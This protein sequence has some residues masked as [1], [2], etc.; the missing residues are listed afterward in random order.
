[1]DRGRRRRRHGR[2]AAAAAGRAAHADVPRAARRGRRAPALDALAAGLPPS[3]FR[4][5]TLA[6]LRA[7]LPARGD[8]RRQLRAA[9]WP[10]CSRRSASLVLRQHASGG[11]AA[12]APPSGRARSEQAARAR[13][14]PRP[15]GP[16]R[17]ARRRGPP[18]VTVGDGATLV[19]LE[20]RWAATA[21]CSDG[22]ASSPGGAASASTWRRPRA[23][24]GATSP[25]RLSP[26]VLLRPVVESAL[27]PT[28]AYLGGPGELRYLALTPPV[29]AAPRRRRGSCPLPA[30]VG[31]AGRAP[32][33]P[34][35][36][37]VRRRRSTE[38]LAPARRA[39]GPAGA[40]A[41][42]AGGARARST[43]APR[44]ARGRATARSSARAVEIDPTLARPDAGR[45]AA[46][47]RRDPGHREEAGAAPQAAAGDRAG[48]DR[49]GADRGAARRQ[50]A[51]AGPDRGAVP[52]A[53][54]PGAARPELAGRDRGL[55]CRRP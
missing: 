33:G 18:G 12:A 22:A 28:V 34:R 37:E 8:R 39:R 4:D 42:A 51:G 50:A 32:G 54:R 17:W 44:S 35:A 40:V 19:M 52:G 10:S 13:R 45:P 41:A 38:L 20:A 11:Q 9:R 2:A 31:R 36:G 55:V 5:A 6:W 1:M 24:R 48:P 29:Y 25:T 3:E 26:N 47:A 27:L 30:L 23:H 46:G 49:P 15:A 14:R 7:A 43:R 16:R 21:W 53:L